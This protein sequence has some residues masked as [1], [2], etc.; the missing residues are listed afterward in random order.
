VIG[1][2]IPIDVAHLLEL[3]L[4]PA[5]AVELLPLLLALL[6]LLVL[7][8]LLLPQPAATSPVT[9]RAA[10]LMRTFMVLEPPPSGSFMS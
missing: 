9:T 1:A 3:P 2:S 10:R 6:A 5:A 8:L 4:L 7:L